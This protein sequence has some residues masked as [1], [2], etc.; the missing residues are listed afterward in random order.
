[1]PDA[2]DRERAIVSQTTSTRGFTLIELLVAVAIVAVLA[3]IAIPQFSSYRRVAFDSRAASDLRNAATAQE[4]Q[5]TSSGNYV[6]CIDSAC[7]SPT[8][9]GFQL[10]DTVRMFMFRLT[11]AGNPIFLG[12]SW[13]DSGSG[14]FWVWRSDAGGMT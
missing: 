5:F 13:S 10:S 12:I 8:L 7:N 3:A 14:K 4:A 9:P 11:F 2:V 1:M 6:Q